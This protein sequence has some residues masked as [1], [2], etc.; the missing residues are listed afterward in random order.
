MGDRS[1]IQDLSSCAFELLLF[2]EVSGEE[3][4][5][6]LLTTPL[7]ISNK[8]PFDCASELSK[9]AFCLFDGVSMEE[10]GNRENQEFEELY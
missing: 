9:A 8:P 2:S 3:T 6:S 4:S 10:S 1:K 7:E 5:P